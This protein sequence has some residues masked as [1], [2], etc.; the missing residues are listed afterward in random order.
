ME[1]VGAEER[2]ASITFTHETW[3][4]INAVREERYPELRIVGWFHTHPGYGV[5]LSGYDLFIH[6]NFFNLPW[7]LAYVIDPVGGEAGFFGWRGE[8]ITR[9][10]GYYARGLEAAG[11]GRAGGRWRPRRSW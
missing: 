8:D 7:Q 10:P 1:A 3:A 2:R 5:F 9:L 11:S 4:H 6:R